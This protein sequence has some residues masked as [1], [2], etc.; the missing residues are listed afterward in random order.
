M[1]EKIEAEQEGHA[2][3]ARGDKLEVAALPRLLKD[4]PQTEAEREEIEQGLP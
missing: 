4:G 2:N 3:D 1:P